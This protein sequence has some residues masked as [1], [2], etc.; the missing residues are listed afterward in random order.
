[1]RAIESGVSIPLSSVKPLDGQVRYRAFC[2]QAMR[3]ALARG[4]TVRRDRSPVSGA[5]LEPFGSVEGLEYR[6]CPDTDSLFLAE[7]PEAAT[8]ARLLR[9]VA[10]QRFAPAGDDSQLTQLRADHVYAPKLEWIQDTLRMHG[11]QRPSLLEAATPP[12]AMSRLLEDSGRFSAVTVVDEMALAHG[13]PAGPGA[14]PAEVVMLLESLDRVDDPRGL[15][16]GV[17]R[18][19]P[20]GGLVFA[21]ALVSSGF[22]MAVLGLDN[23]YLCPPDRT[24]CFS[25][26]GLARL[27]IEAGF[28]LIEVSTPGVLDVEVVQAHL[29]RDPTIRL[30]LFERQLIGSTDAAREQ[31]Q[32]F[33]Q[34]GGLSSFARVVAKKLA[35]AGDAGTHSKRNQEGKVTR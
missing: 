21:T 10:Q 35:A 24:N 18:R 8:W 11:L 30:S 34:R 23:L 29:H 3:Q 6:R 32:A 5:A 28:G 9:E 7:L 14:G 20:E 16:E 22:D 12:S 19:L 15:L 27:L 17:A 31:L 26:S 1:M 25:L 4:P 33:L 2:V 13:A